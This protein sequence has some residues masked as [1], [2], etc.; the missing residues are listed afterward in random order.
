[1]IPPRELPGSHMHDSP[2]TFSR[3]TPQ[4]IFPFLSYRICLMAT[5]MLRCT[6]WNFILAMVCPPDR[7]HVHSVY[8]VS[9]LSYMPETKPAGIFELK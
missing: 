1:M 5:I 7:T 3:S 6:S 4:F 9:Y 2:Q 8:L